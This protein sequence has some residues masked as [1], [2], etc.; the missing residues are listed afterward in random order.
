MKLCMNVLYG[1][2]MPDE[3][4]GFNCLPIVAA[5][6]FYGKGS[7]MASPP[8]KNSTKKNAKKKKENK[9]AKIN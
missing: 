2:R 7:L 5:T 1:L 8:P 4:A 9:A 6:T 3:N